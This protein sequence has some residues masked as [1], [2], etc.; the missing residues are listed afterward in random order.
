MQPVDTINQ[1][2]KLIIMDIDFEKLKKGMRKYLDTDGGD[3]DIE[4]CT[5]L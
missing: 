3:D 5:V 4:N 1:D 2:D